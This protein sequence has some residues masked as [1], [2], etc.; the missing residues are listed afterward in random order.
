MGYRQIHKTSQRTGYNETKAY[1]TIRICLLITLTG[2]YLSWNARFEL[3]EMP[4]GDK[5][6]ACEG[7]EDDA[8]Y[9]IR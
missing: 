7:K 1:P 5:F 2:D 6:Q 4:K 9:P 8:E 3:C